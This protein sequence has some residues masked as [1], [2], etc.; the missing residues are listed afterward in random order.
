[1]GFFDIVVYVFSKIAFRFEFLFPRFIGYFVG[2]KLKEYKEKYWIEDY[3]VKTKRNGK[4]HYFFDLDMFLKNEKGG[5]LPRLKKRKDI[6]KS[7]WMLK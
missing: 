6:E 2:Q 1:M 3:K 7:L 4:Y 5:E